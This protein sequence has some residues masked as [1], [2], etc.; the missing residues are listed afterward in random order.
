[1]GPTVKT[2]EKETRRP[3]YLRQKRL[4][5]TAGPSAWS[6]SI[7]D[8][9]VILSDSDE[10]EQPAQRQPAPAAAQRQDP[11]P[12]AAVPLTPAA[13][14]QEEPIEIRDDEVAQLVDMGFTPEQATQV[15][16][17]SFSS[18]CWTSRCKFFKYMHHSCSHLLFNACD[19]CMSGVNIVWISV[20]HVCGERDVLSMA[21]VL[22]RR[23][24][25]DGLWR[26]L[27]RSS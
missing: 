6:I 16:P 11:S 18:V 12:A 10:E 24:T 4:P 14:V 17:P 5:L 27:S 1:M 7:P 23:C 15:G 13:A 20:Q 19:N 9:V 21:W 26:R 8:E 3:I 22:S 2:A 25:A